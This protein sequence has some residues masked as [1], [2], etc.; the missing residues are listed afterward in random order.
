MPHKIVLRASKKRI[1]SLSAPDDICDWLETK[2]N[3]SEFVMAQ[4]RKAMEEEKR[5]KAEIVESP[6]PKVEWTEEM[7]KLWQE[8]SAIENHY[9]SRKFRPI[10]NRWFEFNYGD[11]GY[12]GEEQ[13]WEKALAEFGPEVEEYFKKVLNLPSGQEYK[14]KEFRIVGPNVLNAYL[15]RVQDEWKREDEQDL[16]DR[17]GGDPDEKV[18]Q[19]WTAYDIV[20]HF[21][22]NKFYSIRAV[23]GELG[24]TYDQAYK[25]VIPWMKAHGFR[26]PG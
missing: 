21:E 6:E 15:E 2:P 14:D 4:L 8:R 26:V 11:S 9:G 20:I 25:N 1:I 22:K 17:C 19:D 3:K 16:R 13:D 12:I 23:A 7:N 10:E 18:F 24:I 5:P